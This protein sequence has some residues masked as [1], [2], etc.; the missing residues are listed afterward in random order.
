MILHFNCITVSEIVSDIFR[1]LTHLGRTSKNN[2]VG[3][4]ESRMNNHEMPTQKCQLLEKA[5]KWKSETLHVGLLHH[6]LQLI[7][8]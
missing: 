3:A 4:I 1:P 2:L 5:G 7:H 8:N 6:D